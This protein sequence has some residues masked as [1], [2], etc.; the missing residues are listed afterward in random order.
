MR[1]NNKTKAEETILIDSE[2]SVD[3][4]ISTIDY[5]LVNNTSFE[6]NK[7]EVTKTDNYGI[8]K[9]KIMSN[10]IRKSDF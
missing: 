4:W 9:N 3:E 10:Y 2:A 1:I 8:F 7:D 6:E 5:D